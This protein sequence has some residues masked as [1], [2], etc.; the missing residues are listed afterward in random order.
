MHGAG[1]L[2]NA[3]SGGSSQQVTGNGPFDF[4]GIA[5]SDS[6]GA[7]LDSLSQ[8]FSGSVVL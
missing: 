3:G 7:T 1:N 4:T 2:D 5:S 6:V 8:Q